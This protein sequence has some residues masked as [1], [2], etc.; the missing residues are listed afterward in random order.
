MARIAL[1]K[2]GWVIDP[3]VDGFVQ[4]DVAVTDLDIVRT[5]GVRAD[6]GLV[7]NRCPLATKIGQR[8]Q[9]AHSAFLTFRELHRDAHLQR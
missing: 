1:S 3:I 6:P 2:P 4:V 5:L 9:V 8:N 7:V